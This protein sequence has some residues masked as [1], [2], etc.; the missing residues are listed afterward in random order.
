MAQPLS[1][2]DIS[3][4][5][6]HV[7]DVPWVS[8]SGKIEVD[9]VESRVLHARPEEGFVVTN[10][11]T[12]PG[13][14]SPMHRHIGPSFAYTIKGA[15]GHDTTYSYRTGTYVFETPGVI[16]RFYSGHEPVTEVI[17]V[18]YATLEFIDPESMEVTGTATPFDVVQSYFESCEA[19][20]FGRPNILR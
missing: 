16:H 2:S 18:V 11:R 20:G 9:G 8:Q 13:V 14:L 1:A 12:G 15:W 3:T 6:M 5:H 7:D 4:L 10:I 17:F 19:A